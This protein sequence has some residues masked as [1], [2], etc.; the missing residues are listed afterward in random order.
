[1]TEQN[2]LDEILSEMRNHVYTPG[3][4]W[5]AEQRRWADSIE[6]LFI[7]AVEAEHNHV[8]DECLGIY[9]EIS[10]RRSVLWRIS[11]E[12]IKRRIEAL[13]IIKESGDP[14]GIKRRGT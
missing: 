11:G 12:E 13:R 10:K 2:K 7:N 14:A 6:Q 5:Y 4:D 8:L 3:I 1:M 9:D